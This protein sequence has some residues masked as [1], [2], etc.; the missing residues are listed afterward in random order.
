MM[1]CSCA[2]LGTA[3]HAGTSAFIAERYLQMVSPSIGYREAAWRG[4]VPPALVVSDHPIVLAAPVLVAGDLEG[5]EM[6]TSN[7]AVFRFK[8]FRHRTA[9]EAIADDLQL[10][11]PQRVR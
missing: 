6:P 2:R 10:G 7:L 3:P 8:G 5:G 4:S 9:R 11:A 1:C